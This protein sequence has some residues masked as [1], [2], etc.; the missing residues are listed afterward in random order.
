L[1]RY[2]GQIV[3]PDLILIDGDKAIFVPA[4]GPA[5]VTVRPGTLKATG[6]ATA[7]GKKIC[8]NG[9]EKKVSVPACQYISGPFATPGTGTLKIAALAGN[10]KAKKT[11]SGR[12]S[13][14]LKGG[15]FQAKFDVQVPAQTLPPGGSDPVK[16][17]SGQGF[18][19]TTNRK[20]RG[21]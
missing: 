19:Q 20:F 6:P 17:Y 12:K 1:T 3:V 7:N 8:L 9:D 10:Q 16:S 13:V 21:T 18:F 4:F 14:L 5:L 11:R 2:K 15:K